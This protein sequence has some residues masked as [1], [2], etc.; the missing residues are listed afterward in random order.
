MKDL[1]VELKK[2]RRKVDK[3]EELSGFKQTLSFLMDHF[4]LM[5]IT[6]AILRLVEGVA[7]QYTSQ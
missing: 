3:V 1:V 5:E 7:E 6:L 2:T 4:V